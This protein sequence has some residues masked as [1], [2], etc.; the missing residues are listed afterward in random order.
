[1]TDD[2]PISDL[3]KKKLYQSNAERV[4]ALASIEEQAGT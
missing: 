2:L 1:V 3:D 4:F